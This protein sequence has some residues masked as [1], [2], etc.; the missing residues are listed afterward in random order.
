MYEVIGYNMKQLIMKPFTVTL[1]NTSAL[2]NGKPLQY[3]YGCGVGGLK[4]MVCD[5][6]SAGGAISAL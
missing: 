3:Y 6:L 5:S 4:P 2:I 1:M